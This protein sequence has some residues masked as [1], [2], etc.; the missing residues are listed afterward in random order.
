MFS[1]PKLKT[2]KKA[3]ITVSLKNLVGV[4]A[5]KNWL[6]HHTEGYPSDGGDEHPNPDAKHRAERAVVPIFRQ[7]SLGAPYVGP[8]IHR[9]ARA[10]GRRL[11]G[12]TEQVIRSGNWSG[13]DTLWRTCLDLNKIV[14]YGKPDGTL[15]SPGPA[16][17]KRH[18][19]LVDGIVGGE[20]RGPMNPDP[21]DAGAIVFG[22]HPASVDA[23]CAVLMGFDP[24]RIPII[25]QAFRC[26]GLP[27]AEWDWPDVRVH[28]S[29]AEW[30]G[31]LPHIPDSST[32]HFT[33]HYGWTGAIERRPLSHAG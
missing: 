5:D 6:P 21:V 10:L 17:R 2:H 13:N 32:F 7:L 14:L 11:F 33:P 15:R 26:T 25:R 30:N 1:L 3:G 8:W 20:G 4:N 12:D 23:V 28:S 16:N 18:L 27:L 22:T 9:R 29:R 19:V 24:E 31:P